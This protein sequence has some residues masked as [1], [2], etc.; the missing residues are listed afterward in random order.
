MFCV[1]CLENHVKFFTQM[2]FGPSLVFDE[3]GLK[4]APFTNL[5]QTNKQTEHA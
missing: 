4:V 1:F 5:K 2:L 3:H